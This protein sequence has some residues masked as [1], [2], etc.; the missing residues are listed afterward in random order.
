MDGSFF[1]FSSFALLNCSPTNCSYWMGFVLDISSSIFQMSS[2]S[3]SSPSRSSPILFA[4]L[5]ASFGSLEASGLDMAKTGEANDGCLANERP[6]KHAQQCTSRNGKRDTGNRGSIPHFPCERRPPVRQ[7]LAVRS[8]LHRVLHPI[9]PCRA[10]TRPIG[11][12]DTS[13]T[14]IHL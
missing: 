10:C 13:V 6:C 11:Q 7:D 2:A 3:G 1:L 14:P 8:L 12:L 4:N 9:Q 5:T